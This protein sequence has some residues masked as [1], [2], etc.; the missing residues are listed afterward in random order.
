MSTEREM[1][2]EWKIERVRVFSDA[3]RRKDVDEL[4][5]YVSDDCIYSASVGPEPGM[6]YRGREEVRRG[7]IELIKHDEKAEARGGPI[8][9][10]ED[11]VVAEWA[12]IYKDG[13][14]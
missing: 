10:A 13:S 8:Y 5:S 6:T 12:F 2:T 4:M 3:W 11:V 1:L 14:G 9:A 7:F